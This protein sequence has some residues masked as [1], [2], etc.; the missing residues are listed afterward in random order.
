MHLVRNTRYLRQTN[1][2]KRKLK[3]KARKQLTRSTHQKKKE[4]YGG[5][6]LRIKVFKKGLGMG[7]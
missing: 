5:K 6:S 7:L 2:N 3:A 4:S 1:I